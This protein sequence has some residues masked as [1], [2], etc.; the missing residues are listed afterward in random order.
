M[1]RLVKKPERKSPPGRPRP[2][3]RRE[4]ILK[5]ILHRLGG[6]ECT[7]RALDRDKLSA[8]MN[9]AMNLL[10]PQNEGIS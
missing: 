5:Y 2:R 7:D 4:K 3:P 6:V 10:D 9:A 1:N 8:L